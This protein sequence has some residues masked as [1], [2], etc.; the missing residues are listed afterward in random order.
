MAVMDTSVGLCRVLCPG[1]GEKGVGNEGCDTCT[2]RYKG[3]P[4]VGPGSVAGYVLVG[5]F[6]PLS[7]AVI[8]R[9]A[10]IKQTDL[11]L[12]HFNFDSHQ[13]VV[14]KT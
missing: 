2:G 10:L 4:A 5:S 14:H 11:S 8:L 6:I 1:Q 12:S 13:Y 7:H 9:F 3:V